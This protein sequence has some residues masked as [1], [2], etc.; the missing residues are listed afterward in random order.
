MHGRLRTGDVHVRPILGHFRPAGYDGWYVIEQ[1]TVL[2]DEPTGQ[3][4]LADVRASADH[5]RTVLRTA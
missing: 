5:L 1:D 2:D 3:S 4:P